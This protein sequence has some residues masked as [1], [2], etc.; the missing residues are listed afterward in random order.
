M[1]LVLLWFWF[2]TFLSGG[3]VTEPGASHFNLKYSLNNILTIFPYG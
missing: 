1:K 2:Y 3:H